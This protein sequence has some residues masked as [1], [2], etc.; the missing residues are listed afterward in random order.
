MHKFLILVFFGL[1]CVYSLNNYVLL[2]SS[3][4]LLISLF[5]YFNLVYVCL[6]LC[7]LETC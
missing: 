6:L 3:W 7:F 1:S 5:S 2:E 4:A